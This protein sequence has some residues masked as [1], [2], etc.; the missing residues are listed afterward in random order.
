MAGEWE[1]KKIEDVAE[2][3][4]GGTPSTKNTDNF[5][6]TIPWLTPKDMSGYPYRYISRGERNITEKGFANSSARLL[7]S[8][9]V[10]LTTRAPVGYIAIAKNPVTTNQ[11]FHSLVLKEGFDHEFVYYLLL[12]ARDYLKSQATGTTFGEL[13]GSTLK[14]L[15]FVFPPMA[16]Q[17]AIA[18]ILGTLDDKIELNRRMNETLEAIAKATFKSWFVDFDPV[19]AKSEGRAPHLPKEIANLFPLE[20]QDS[21]LGKIPAGWRIETLDD[22]LELAYGKGLKEDKRRPGPIPVFGSNG[23]VGWHDVNLLMGQGL[24][25]AAK[26]TLGL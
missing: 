2:V 24:W 10:L 8:N 11:G 15:C 25:S 1:I 3:I 17:R 22:I 14:R 4:G 16:D 7:P 12:N 13:S 23:Q 9:A 26:V 19:R 21:E 18:H 6:G 5:G 20:F